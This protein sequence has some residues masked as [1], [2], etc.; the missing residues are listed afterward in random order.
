MQ[1]NSPEGVLVRLKTKICQ[2][3]E[4]TPTML[5]LLVDHFVT[6]NFDTRKVGSHYTRVNTYNE[7]NSPRMTVKVFFKFL[8]IIQIRKIEFNITVVT[9]KGNIGL[10]HE[11]INFISDLPNAMVYD[12]KDRDKPDKE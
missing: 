2:A 11:E 3:L 5:K 4:I 9:A 10:V 7:L 6:V 8:H 12:K 1:Q